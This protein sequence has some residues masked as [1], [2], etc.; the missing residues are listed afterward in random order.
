[1]GRSSAVAVPTE[2]WVNAPDPEY[3]GSQAKHVV[4]DPSGA[5]TEF[6]AT[7]AQASAYL[8]AHLIPGQDWI[9]LLNRS[10]ALYVLG[11][12]AEAFLWA[13]L[14][15]DA[16]RTTSTLLNLAVI[17]ETSGRF[18]DAMPLIREA[19]ALD[20]SDP[21]AGSLLADSL[22]RSGDWAEGWSVHT[23]YHANWNFLRPFIPQWEGEDL[24]GRRVLVLAGGGYGDNV[25]FSR[26]IPRLKGAGAAHVTY[27]CHQTFAPLARTLAGVDAV[28]ETSDGYT[29]ALD[30]VRPSD[31]DCFVSVLSLAGR[32]GVRVDSPPATLVARR[33]YIH[34]DAD[35]LR[36]RRLCLVRG[37][38]P[39]VG[40][41]WRAGEHQM[42]RKHRT[43][44]PDATVRILSTQTRGGADWVSLVPDA[45]PPAGVSDRVSVLRPALRDWADTAAVVACCDLVVTV[46]TGLAHLAGAMHV[47]TWVILPGFSAWP[48]L[49]DRDDSPLY[50]TMR[51]FRNRGE[52][53]AGAV[54]AVCDA[55]ASTVPHRRAA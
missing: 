6:A 29:S 28:L 34:A 18:R 33:P 32:F 38:T 51:L 47:P 27:L 53:M 42:P 54:S 21:F 37:A 55:L 36:L 52:G 5:L 40:F 22:V 3:K 23:R 16:R 12:T 19:N 10:S 11:R 1:M 7:Q 39:V 30:D 43:L 49:L 41:C 44:S 17:L 15:L 2:D 4:A 46:D 35:R 14:A 8:A 13:R 31:F 48:Y 20:P 24:H 25:L 9:D 45:A 50:P 26:W